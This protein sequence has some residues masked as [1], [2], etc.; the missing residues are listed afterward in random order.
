MAIYATKG[1]NIKELKAVLLAQRKIDQSFLARHYF[2]IYQASIT[3]E[4]YNYWKNVNLLINRSGSI[5][6]APPAP[7]KGNAYSKDD[8][9]EK[10]LGYFEAGNTVL[11]RFYMLRSDIASQ[12]QPYCLDPRFGVYYPNYPRECYQCTLLDNS[13]HQMPA[14]W[15][16]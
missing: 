9:K 14:W 5:F 6:D 11:S 2:T 1:N 10:V 3:L 15:P 7:I 16:Q 8:D 12:I 4:A 13:S